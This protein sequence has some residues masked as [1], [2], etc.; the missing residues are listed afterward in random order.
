MEQLL[1]PLNP[2]P[3][4][5]LEK[6]PQRS[7][8]PLY[9]R[10][11]TTGVHA[12]KERDRLSL[13]KNK[14]CSFQ[15]KTNHDGNKSSKA[16]KTSKQVYTRLYEQG[17]AKIKA[18]EQHFKNRPLPKN[19]TFRPALNLPLDK[20]K[21]PNF[22]QRLYKNAMDQKTKRT[23]RAKTAQPQGCTF[24]PQIN[25]GST[26]R[27]NKSTFDRLYDQGRKQRAAQ[28]LD[29][30]QLKKNLEEKQRRKLTKKKR[31]ERQTGCINR[32]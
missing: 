27:N 13:Q 29:Y 23:E 22:G 21:R 1:V 32:A 12:L 4:E 3:I 11:Y 19:V 6:P 16:S 5:P 8:S 28:E 25:T 20:K 24:R 9:E 10:L 17:A 14:E 31:E 26:P 2:Q 18:R 30:L 15:P 7:L